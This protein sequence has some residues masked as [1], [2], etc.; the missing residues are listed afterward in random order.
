MRFF[1]ADFF[2]VRRLHWLD[3]W[4]TVW[5]PVEVVV[6]AHA[7]TPGL[8]QPLG[9]ALRST[10]DAGSVPAFDRVEVTVLT[11]AEAAEAAEG[12]EAT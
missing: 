12:A 2:A 11:A 4:P 1:F 7:D 10:G 6:A 5:T 8:G 3:G 9:V